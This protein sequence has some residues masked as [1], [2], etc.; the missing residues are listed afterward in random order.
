MIRR[1]WARVAG[2]G[3]RLLLGVVMASTVV[4]GLGCGKLQGLDAPTTPLVTFQVMVS[5]DPT[6]FR[7]AIPARPL[8]LQVALVWGAQWQTE[9]FCILQPASKAAA[10]IIAAGCRD[11]LGFVPSRVAASV[12]V[13]I[14]TQT[15][16]DLFSLPGA[17]VM[18]GDVTSRVAYG[19]IVVYDDDGDGTLDLSVPHRTPSGGPRRGDRMIDPVDSADI[20]YGASFVTMTA[21]DQ[22]VAFTEGTFIPSAFYPRNGCRDPLKAFSVLAAGGYT[23]PDP[24][25][26]LEAGHPLLEDPSLCSESLP[27][28]PAA[29]VNVAVQDPAGVR[30]VGCSEIT[31]DSTIRYREPPSDPPDFTDRMTACAPLPAFDAGDQSQLIQLVV[32]GRSADRC[33][34][35]THYTL[36]GCRENVSCPVPDWDFTATPPAWWQSLCPS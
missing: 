25:K 1:G 16:I 15:S 10:D 30:E 22:R 24:V 34:G 8:S 28:D 14:G 19:S 18:V 32:S 4:G 20:V 35:L 21:P 17:D 23:V 31:V 11:P 9:P 36:R 13:T 3:V 27:T 2:L 26:E 12:P 29:L 33:K 5:G 6:P 7:A